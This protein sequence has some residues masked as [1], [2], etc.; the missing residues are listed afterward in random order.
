M[1]C[2]SQLRVLYVCNVAVVC[3]IAC[4]EESRIEL[5]AITSIAL[6]KTTKIFTASARD[7][8]CFSI[9]TAHRTLDL[10]CATTTLRDFLVQHL[11]VLVQQMHHVQHA[12]R[13]FPSPAT[14]APGF[15][16]PLDT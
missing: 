14:R 6:G 7:S 8:H 4:Y 10:E 11:G 2:F 13:L 1:G 9:I 16:D 3:V 12:P 5:H 15:D